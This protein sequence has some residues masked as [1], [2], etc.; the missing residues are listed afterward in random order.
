LSS[1]AFIS[2]YVVRVLFFFSIFYAK[3]KNSTEVKKNFP[4]RLSPCSHQSQSLDVDCSENHNNLREFDHTFQ[5]NY[6]ARK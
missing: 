6:P 2:M 1:N 3:I 4:P 5:C